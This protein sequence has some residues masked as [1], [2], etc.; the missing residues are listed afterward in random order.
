[1]IFELG[2]IRALRGDGNPDGQ[3]KSEAA[4]CHERE[5]LPRRPG[6]GPLQGVSNLGDAAGRLVEFSDRGF[7]RFGDEKPRLFKR[8]GGASARPRRGGF[9]NLLD[10]EPD[11]LA[12]LIERRRRDL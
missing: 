9:L 8:L 2:K 6:R 11:R 10:Q 7:R 1:L 3:E 12:R 5:V 4:A